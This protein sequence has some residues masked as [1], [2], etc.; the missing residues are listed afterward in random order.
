[1]KLE[2]GN[3]QE[4]F[5]SRV[6]FYYELT[7]IYQQVVIRQLHHHFNTQQTN[8]QTTSYKDYFSTTFS[9]RSNG[10]DSTIV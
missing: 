6:K 8:H 9:V 7:K 5:I 4:K 1:M 2:E 3:Y 10:L